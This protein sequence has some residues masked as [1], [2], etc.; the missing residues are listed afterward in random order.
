MS[1]MFKKKSGAAFKPKAPIARPR[2][3]SQVAKPPQPSVTADLASSKPIAV[4]PTP[5]TQPQPTPESQA[6]TSVGGPPGDTTPAIGASSSGAATIPAA[7]TEVPT[8][9]ATP[10]STTTAAETHE[11]DAAPR[12][13][14]DPTSS[15]VLATTEVETTPADDTPGTARSPIGKTAGRRPRKRAATSKTDDDE[16]APAPDGEAGADGA[17]PKKRRNTRKA[18]GERAARVTKRNQSDSA[19]A[20]APERQRTS[21]SR[22]RTATPEGAEEQVVDLSSMTMADLTMDLRIGKKSKVHDMLLAREREKLAAAKL[23][24]AGLHPD[25]GDSQAG[26]P[27]PSQQPV[28]FL[29]KEVPSSEPTGLQYTMIGGQIVVD[30][31]SLSLDRHE[32]ARQ[33]QLASGGMMAE[34][35]EDDFTNHI[36][37]TSFRTGSKLRGPN[38]WSAEDTELF[39]R[40]LGMLGTDFTLIAR[41]FPSRNRR[42]VKMKFNREEKA[43]PDRINAVLAGGSSMSLDMDEYKHWTKAEYESVEDIMAAH[44]AKEVEFEEQTKRIADEKAEANRKKKEA[45]FADDDGDGSG[46]G[47]KKKKGKKKGAVETNLWGEIV[48]ETPIDAA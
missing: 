30:Q 39:Y 22:Q 6:P 4:P 25:G 37:E 24:K 9:Q 46:V 42:H 34:M 13:P 36:T 2:P 33:Q 7:L 12:A 11:A 44:R 1:S 17:P 5:E 3:P 31:S 47:K 40:G 45:L 26:T 29:D 35:E 43:N 8:Q 15:T 38:F 21:R 48:E 20:E 19:D 23:K 32:R 41:M 28:S 14:D 18:P 16:S 27:A 10:I